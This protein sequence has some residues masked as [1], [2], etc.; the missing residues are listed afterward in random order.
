MLQ[1]RDKCG[2]GAKRRA[3]RGRSAGRQAGFALIVVIW[4]LGIIAV[5]II[6]FMTSA[7]WRLQAASNIAGADQAKYAAEGAIN[8]AI[9]AVL[10]EKDAGFSNPQQGQAQQPPAHAGEPHFCSLQSALVA[11]EIQDEGGKVDLNSA[12]PKL[13]QAMFNG[14]G[15]DMR[16]ADAM[17]NAIVTFRSIPSNSLAAKFPEY[18]AAGKPFGPKR[19]PFQTILELDQVAG[20]DQA[21]FRQLLPFVTVYSRRPGVDPQSAPPAL[22][23]ALAGYPPE[24]V[25]ALAR[26]AGRVDRRDPRFPETFKQAGSAGSFTIHAEAMLPTGH[27]AVLEA[28][29]DTVAAEGGSYAIHELRRGPARR[30]DELRDLGR[31]GGAGAPDC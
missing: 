15:M 22:F 26:D 5:L 1:G 11:V 16:D 12:P 7:R 14:F 13:L 28:L 10:T 30:L 29:V 24:D 31:Q 9:L 25:R 2:A 8:A 23:A 20:I 6:S 17:A 19:A 18:E 27:S 3:P 4:G 21:L